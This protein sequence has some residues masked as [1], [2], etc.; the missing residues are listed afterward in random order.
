MKIERER[1]KW[2]TKPNGDKECE[3]CKSRIQNRPGF[4]RYYEGEHGSFGSI[5]WYPNCI[6]KS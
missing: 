1:H 2:I 3:K 6:K 5:N 4:A